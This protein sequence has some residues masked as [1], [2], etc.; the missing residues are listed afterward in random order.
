MLGARPLAR[1][2]VAREEDDDGV[3][4]GTGESTHPL[5]GM[6]RT[7]ITEDI[8]ARCHAL[9]KLLRKGGQRSLVHTE[10]PQAVPGE[11]HGHPSLVGFDRRTC[12]VRRL[13]LFPDGG[14]P[15]AS[16]HRFTKREKFVSSGERWRAGQ[17][18]VLYVIELEHVAI[19][20][21]SLHLIQH[22]GQ[23]RLHSQ[24]L[25][26]FVRT[27]VRIF[28]VFQ[29]ALALMFPNELD[30]RWY[31]RPPILGK[32]FQVHEDG[33]DAGLREEGYSVLGVLVEIGI[34][35]ALIHEVRIA[36]DVEEHP[37]EV[38]ELQHFEAVRIARYRCFNALAIVAD[39]LLAARLHLRNDRETIARGR[40]GE[41][42]A[43]P[44]TLLFV[45][46]VSLLRDRHRRGFHPVVFPGCVG[47]VRLL[48]FGGWRS[49]YSWSRLA[50]NGDLGPPCQDTRERHQHH[51]LDDHHD[52][53]HHDHRRVTEVLAP[54]HES[55]SGIALRRSEGQYA[56]RARSGSSQS[57]SDDGAKRGED[58]CSQDAERPEYIEHAVHMARGHH[59][60]D[61]HH[62]YGGHPGH[63][64]PDS[65]GHVRPSSSHGQTRVE[66]DEHQLDQG[67]SDLR[68]NQRWYGQEHW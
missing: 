26:D 4:V 34:E 23:R 27:D 2:G 36:V 17:E 31:V 1:R 55:R 51:E 46:E 6:V 54:D 57:P 20:R 62:A 29:K 42:R 41:D 35:D 63:D 60:D 9:L 39:G 65:R 30:E 12:R 45:L 25:L 48:S 15:L 68:G 56:L 40:P 3:Q 5:V 18:N 10:R 7:G 66:R 13:D 16:C 52:G 11:C 50:G 67:L 32:P 8:R 64:G 14:N 33:G 24:R 49:R 38:V 61:E 43:I 58:D 21:S 47:H 37:A 22:V 19:P 59:R 28:A 53:D 44:S